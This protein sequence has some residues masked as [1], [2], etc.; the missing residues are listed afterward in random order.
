[1]EVITRPSPPVPL[2]QRP[3]PSMVTNDGGR[4]LAL[5]LSSTTLTHFDEFHHFS[6]SAC[7]SRALGITTHCHLLLHGQTLSTEKSKVFLFSGCEQTVEK[8]QGGGREAASDPPLR[9]TAGKN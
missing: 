1:M 2:R 6:C 3:G 5:A 9:L 7:H 8:P 4:N